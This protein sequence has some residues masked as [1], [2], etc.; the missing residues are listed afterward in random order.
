MAKVAPMSEELKEV[1]MREHPDGLWVV[2]ADE[3]PGECAAD[4]GMM[5]GHPIAELGQ[6][7]ESCLDP[8]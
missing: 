5:V 7:A 3:Y 4:V 6:A 1:A 8:R 2:L